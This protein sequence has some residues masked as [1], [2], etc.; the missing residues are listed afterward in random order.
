[1]QKLLTLLCLILVLSTAVIPQSVK[2]SGGVK[3]TGGVQAGTGGSGGGG[4]TIGNITTLADNESSATLTISHNNNGNFLLVDVAQNYSDDTVA[5]TSVTFNSVSMTQEANLTWNT[6]RHLSRWKLVSPASGIHN[7]VLS[8]PANGAVCFI[9]IRSFS[10]VNAS[11][12]TGTTVTAT[13]SSTSPSCTA[14]SA[15]GELV[16]DVIAAAS[17]GTGVSSPT[18]SV[19]S[20]Q[21]QDSNGYSNQASDSLN[22]RSGTSHESGAASVVMDWTLS[23]SREWGCIATPLKP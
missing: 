7:V 1:M 3:T 15:S 16:V 9:T 20:S 6:N 13:A 19:G 22:V 5:P 11:T 4:P 23:V 12:P 2:T 8:W 21:T 14:S 10:G 18:A 17:D